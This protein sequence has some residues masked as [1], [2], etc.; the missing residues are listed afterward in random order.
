MNVRKIP[1]HILR[2]IT[3]LYK[4][5]R[6]LFEILEYDDLILYAIDKEKT[7]YFKIIS[8]EKDNVI[9][10]LSPYHVSS[11]EAVKIGI[12]IKEIGTLFKQW[13]GRLEEFSEHEKI[14]MNA[15]PILRQYSEEFYNQFT[16][17]DADADTQP[18]DLEKQIFLFNFLG[19]LSRTLSSL[20]IEERFEEV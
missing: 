20:E 2:E 7:F 8:Q 13:I 1:L 11:V 9:V 17:S 14:K 5:E 4:E 10:E 12:P 18:F 15:D 3:L 6:K 16:I 19:A